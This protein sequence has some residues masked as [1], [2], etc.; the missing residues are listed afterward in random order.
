[1]SYG[2]PLPKPDFVKLTQ[3]DVPTLAKS[4][5]NDL[6]GLTSEDKHKLTTFL[7]SD[8]LR[9]HAGKIIHEIADKQQM[10][11]YQNVSNNLTKETSRKFLD[12]I[13]NDFPRSRKE[14]NDTELNTFR[15]IFGREK[16]SLTNNNKRSRK[17]R[18]LRGGSKKFKRRASNKSMQRR[19]KTKRK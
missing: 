13:K 15:R 3:S 19:R 18:H 9:D 7:L 12:E 14:V 11:K 17:S 8:P 4:R 1:M 2:E 6:R 5:L 10:A 16:Q